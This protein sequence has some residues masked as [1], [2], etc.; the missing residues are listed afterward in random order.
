TATEKDANGNL[1]APTTS[2]EAVTVNPLAA[3]LAPVAA[4]GV[5]G[6]PIALNLRLTINSETGLNGDSPANSLASLVIG[7]IPLGPALSDAH[8]HTFT[9]PSGNPAVA[10]SVLSTP[11]L[12]STP[13]IPY[14]TPFRSTATEKDANGNLSAPTTSTEAVTVNPLAPTLSPVAETGVE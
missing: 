3:T 11:R 5:E 6:S 12:P 4:T 1:G 14:T 10:V 13:P 7:A 2:T 9:P 8:A